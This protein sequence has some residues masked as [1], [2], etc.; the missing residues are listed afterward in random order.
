MIVKQKLEDLHL[1]DERID[2]VIETLELGADRDTNCSKC[3]H[4]SMVSPSYGEYRW[5]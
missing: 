3:P 1:T 5:I 4:N 2:G